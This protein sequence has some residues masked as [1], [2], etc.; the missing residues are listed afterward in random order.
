MGEGSPIEG[1]LLRPSVYLWRFWAL[2]DDD[3]ETY[4]YEKGE[5]LDQTTTHR[6]RITR[7]RS[8]FTEHPEILPA[9]R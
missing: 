7:Q 9:Y 8:P 2:Y 1:L 3:G 5:D 4:N 6:A